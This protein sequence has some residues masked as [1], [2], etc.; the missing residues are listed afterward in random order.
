MTHNLEI[1]KSLGMILGS[2]TV[3]LGNQIAETLSPEFANGWGAVLEKHGLP[4]VLLAVSIIGGIKLYNA[5]RA[6]E[7]A[8]IDE[9]K[10]SLIDYKTESDA[11]EKA[12]KDDAIAAEASRRELI[13]EMQ[14]QTN[15]IRSKQD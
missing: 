11:R 9:A 14:T 15:V 2:S 13:R 12:R 5:L 8:R 6:S 10:K 7:T 1:L 4:V 3:W